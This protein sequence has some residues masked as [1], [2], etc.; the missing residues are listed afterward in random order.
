[1]TIKTQKNGLY[2]NIYQFKIKATQG[3]H[4]VNTTKG[5]LVTTVS[6]NGQAY[7]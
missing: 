3:L 4:Y 6:F 1:M 2:F 5:E 7:N